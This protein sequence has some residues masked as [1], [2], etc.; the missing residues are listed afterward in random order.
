MHIDYEENFKKELD[1]LNLA[2]KEAVESIDGPVLVL[3]G[4]GTGKTQILSARIGNILR[5]T[6]SGP[7]NILCLTYTEAG[8]IAMRKR[9]LE[10]IGPEAYNVHIYT[11]HGFCNQ[12]IQENLDYFGIR[13]LQPVTDLER[14]ELIQ[15]MIDD[16]EVTHPL[17]RLK[18]DAHYDIKPLMYLF[19][20]M[21][22]ENWTSEFISNKIDEFLESLPTHPDYVYKRKYKE[23]QKGDVKQAQVDEVTKKLEKLRAASQQLDVYTQRMMDAGRYDYQ[24]MILWVIK[25]FDE[26][27]NILLNYQ[28]RYHYFLVDEYQDTNGAQNDILKKLS[29]YWD[30]PN[31]FVVGDDDQSIYRFQGANVMNIKEFDDA[32][33]PNI[34]RVILTDNYRSSQKILDASK[35][36]IDNNHE[37]LVNFIPGLSKD[38]Q[39][40]GPNAEITISPKIVEYQNDIQQEVGLL[41]EL[42]RIIQ[43]GEPLEE[44][45]VIYRNHSVVEDLLKVLVKRGIPVNIKKK[46]NILELPFIEN[47]IELLQYV[48]KENEQPDSSEYL[49]YRVMHFDFFNIDHRDI[50]KISRQIYSERKKGASISWNEVIADQKKLKELNLNSVDEITLLESNLNFWVSALQNMTLQ[51]LFEKMLTQGKIIEHVMRLHDRA[52]YMQVLTSFFNFIKDETAKNPKLK[53]KSF[54][55]ILVRM[56]NVNISLD[57]NKLMHSTQ[58]INFITAHSSKGLE[59]DKVFMLSCNAKVW[60]SKRSMSNYTFPDNIKTSDKEFQLEDERRLFYVG[61]TRAKK[62]LNMYYSASTDDGKPK[63][64]S[65]FLVD[66]LDKQPELLSFGVASDEDVLQYKTEVLL[67]QDKPEIELIDK[68]LIDESLKQFRLSVTGLSKYLACPIQFYFENIIRIPT[69]RSE[70]MGFG[71]AIHYSLEV[72]FNRMLSH[73]NKEFPSIDDLLAIFMEAMEIY[74]SH[75]TDD[76]YERKIQHAKEILPPY[77][78]HYVT[79]WN[80]NVKT[81]YSIDNAQ[82]NGIPIAGA[83]DKLEFHDNH[84]NVIDY[85]TG[86]SKNVKKYKSMSPPSETM[87][88][89]GDYWRQIVFYK[90]LLDSDLSSRWTMVSG[91]MEFIQSNDKEQYVNEKVTVSPED[92]QFV[93]KLIESTYNKIM[94][95]EFSEG[96]GK[97]DCQW[98]NFV[99]NNFRSDE[100][101]IQ[102]VDLVKL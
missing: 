15:H 48:L 63:E 98:C 85:K 70:S 54:L 91:E 30:E 93:I 38:L 50:A 60:E 68:D 25:A 18:G 61:M 94:N 65:R 80:K 73:E 59:F 84:V 77:Y 27:E 100:L 36:L 102:E 17:K 58:G 39:G 95:H 53:L 19:D 56:E 40:K 16:F 74:R 45:A 34:K 35:V 55:Q 21:K 52:W 57:L 99:R 7:N 33:K 64:K 20:E 4:P 3:A 37:R 46:V 69:A 101:D 9:L 92:E 97:D 83:I 81:E 82:I 67:N 32:H 42:E 41:N 23:F 31:V 29:A 86:S 62:E 72:F 75:F 11:F 28:E 6:D 76:E 87:E 1:K 71:N 49:L 44:V 26:N 47:I 22:K 13:G 12:V 2:Q 96:C 66:I 24:D 90:I 89:G 5:S 88:F 8:T 43:S 14:A 78:E 79:R 10:F 51:V